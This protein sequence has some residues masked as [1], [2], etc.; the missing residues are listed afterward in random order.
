MQKVQAG[1]VHVEKI[2][3]VYAI[4]THQGSD[5]AAPRYAPPAI[6]TLDST[7]VN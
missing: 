7:S 2:C 4:L 1:C 6:Q 3:L 5:I